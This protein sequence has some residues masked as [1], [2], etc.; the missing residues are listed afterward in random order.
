MGSSQSS[1]YTKPADVPTKWFPAFEA[2]LPDATGKVAAVTGCTTGTGYV[3]AR[4]LAKKGATVY[5]LN[6]RS[7]RS[8]VNLPVSDALA[9]PRRDNDMN[10]PN[11]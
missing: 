11:A 6:R 3:A 4:C 2:D 8:P 7:P 10:P 9:I 1:S 5:M